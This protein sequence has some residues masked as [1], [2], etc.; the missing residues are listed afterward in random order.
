MPARLALVGSGGKTTALFTLARELAPP[1][2][3]TATTHLGESQAQQGDHHRVITDLES[4]RLSFDG[5][6]VEVFTGPVGTDGRTGGLAGEVLDCLV[7][8]ADQAGISVLVEADGSRQKS[9]KAPATHE[10]PIPQWVRTVVVCVGMTGLNQPLT[11]DLVHRAQI[12]RELTGM[13]MDQPVTVEALRDYLCHPMGGLK[14]IPTGARRLVILNQADTPELQSAGQRLAKQLIS[15]YDGV[16]IASLGEIG[17]IHAVIEPTAGVILAAGASTRL[18][19][20]K[21]TLLWRGE[22]LV[23]HVARTALAAGLDPVVVVTG[24]V[25]AEVEAALQGLPVIFVNNPEWQNGQSSSLRVGLTNVPQHCG[26]AIFLLSDQ[27][28]T[29]VTLI[30]GLMEVHEHQLAPVVAPMVDGRRG[31]PVLFDRDTFEDLKAIQG[32]VGGRSIFSKYPVE[33]LP[34]NDATQLLDVDTPEDYKNLLELEGL[35]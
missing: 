34:W 27:P 21:Q 23:R 30:H 13:E 11:E 15:T 35:E 2:W 26:S 25:A 4:L 6:G 1:V 29:P 9:L 12:F 8:K 18:G 31:N 3:V 14:N 16:V 32:D 17:G 19:R 28:Q 10:P 24:A 22:P 7:S 20:A 33:W 5:E